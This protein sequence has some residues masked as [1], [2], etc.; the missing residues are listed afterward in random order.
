MKTL[1]PQDVADMVEHWTETPANGYLGSPYGQNFKSFL[2]QPQKAVAA[3]SFVQKLQNDVEI[4]QIL[5]SDTVGIYAAAQGVDGTA[6]ILSV[7]G[8]KF[9]LGES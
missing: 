9:D 6:I 3:N 1:N 7:A 2:Q 8:R 5:P 4:L